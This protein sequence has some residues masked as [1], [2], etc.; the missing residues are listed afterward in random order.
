[1]RAIDVPHADAAPVNVA[2]TDLHPCI[3]LVCALVIISCALNT[4]QDWNVP[5]L[6]PG[7]YVGKV[8]QCF[9]LFCIVLPLHPADAALV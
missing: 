5:N 8:L 9:C 6:L 2:S 1:M 4:W 3:S 7:K